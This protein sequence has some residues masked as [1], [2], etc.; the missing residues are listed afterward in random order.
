M[1]WVSHS[2]EIPTCSWKKAAL[3]SL[4]IE[5][6]DGKGPWHTPKPSLR[7]IREGAFGTSERIPDYHE[8]LF[9][10]KACPEE[11]EGFH[12]GLPFNPRRAF[13]GRKENGDY[14]KLNPVFCSIKNKTGG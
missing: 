5:L 8:I 12:P 4:E 11:E 2:E 3:T 9:P 14:W 7:G 6:T 1:H 10:R 13:P